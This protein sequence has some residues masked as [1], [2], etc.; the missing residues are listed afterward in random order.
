MTIYTAVR[1][2]L[3]LVHIP[4]DDG[5]APS[6]RSSW[7]VFVLPVGEPSVSGLEKLCRDLDICAAGEL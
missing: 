1:T 6:V 7:H 2:S 5:R 3:L 4:S